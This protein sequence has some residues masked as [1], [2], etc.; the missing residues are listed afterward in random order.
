M[1]RN[2]SGT[3]IPPAGNPVVT[4]T[5]ITSPWANT[6][7]TDLGNEITASLPR[8]GQAPM[9]AP[10]KT[11]DGSAGAPGVSFNSE[12]STGLYRP[13]A[14][15]LGISVGGVE[16]LRIDSSGNIGAGIAPVATVKLY[17]NDGTIS[18][19]VGYNY[20]ANTVSGIG[21]NSAHALGLMTSGAERMR[22]DTSGNVGVGTA[23][24]SWWGGRRGVQIGGAGGDASLLCSPG[25]A[26]YAAMQSNAYYD[27]S[28]VLR[29]VN[30]G[31]STMY[32]QNNGVHAWSSGAS[33]AAGAAITLAE[34][35]RIDASGNVGIGR[36]PSGYMLDVAG[37]LRL[38]PTNSAGPQVGIDLYDSGGGA[39]EGLY[40][41]WESASRTDMADLY[42]VGNSTAGGDMIF[43][44]NSANTG[45]SSE[46]ARI[47][48]GGNL[49]LG[50]TSASNT[51]NVGVT[52]MQNT[53][54]GSVGIGHASGTSSGNGYM[55]FAYAGASIGNITQNGTT[56]V[57]YNTTSDH[58]L[59]QDPMPVTASGAI[60]DAGNPVRWKW[61]GDGADGIGFLAHEMQALLPGAVTGS[62][63]AVDADGKPVYQSMEYGNS[64][65]VAVMWAELK[66]L[67]ARIAALEG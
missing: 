40:I 3:Y 34:R 60:I 46:R 58:R 67:R 2:G 6:L 41:R 11:V 32:E 65:I 55:Q 17:L 30:T 9:T 45:S 57:A 19:L 54:V 20:S 8:D 56:A 66:S 61:K 59:K 35:M 12:S 50:V 64:G 21:T 47:D 25:T 53:T 43:A 5:N 10:L 49:L 52:L 48:A 62:K 36:T 4:N 26:N 13:T 22:I 16:R 28:V 18:T 24:S 15:T 23:P 29:A 27:A 33:V 51:P 31:S 42:A 38:A 14:G 63:D 7:V 1:A 37:P 39:G 44:T